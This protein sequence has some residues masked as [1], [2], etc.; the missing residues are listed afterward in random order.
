MSTRAA[1]LPMSARELALTLL[2][3][4]PLGIMLMLMAPI[5][6]DPGYHALADHRA[7]FGIPNFANVVS[8]LPFLIVGGIGLRLCLRDGA[9]GAT[10]AWAVF[11]LGVLLVAFGSGY[12]HAQ[13]NSDALTWDRLPMTIAFMALFAALV[14]EHVRPEFEHGMLRGAILVG[15]VSVGWWR[16]TDDLRLYAW[17]QFAPLVAL[18]YIALAF[19][20]RYSHRGYLI[21]GLIFYALAKVAEHWDAALWSATGALVS[22]HTVKHLLA[23]LAPYCVYLMLRKRTRIVDGESARSQPMTARTL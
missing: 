19:P 8:N 5:P 11:F 14:A 3:L 6:Q 15:L 7:L 17:V 1:A 2:L 20:A 4:A 22:G 13:P 9:N 23:A 12:Y 10:R 21:A 18:V 16:Y